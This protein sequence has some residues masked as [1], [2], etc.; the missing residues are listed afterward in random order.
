M[1]AEFPGL[2]RDL[3]KLSVE[4]AQ[5]AFET[6]LTTSEGAWRGIQAGS[7]AGRGM[8]ALMDK[9]AKITGANAEASFSFAL[10][11]RQVCGFRPDVRLPAPTTL[12]LGVALL[13]TLAGPRAYAAGDVVLGEKLFNQCKICHTIVQGKNGIA[14][15]L[16]GVIGR[17]AGTAPGFKYSD[18]MVKAG[19]GGLVW[20]EI[21]LDE[22][23]KDPK[24]K[25][26][27]NKMTFPGLGKDEDRANIIAFLKAT[28]Q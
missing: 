2:L 23:L 8:G 20:D 6:F 7:Q 14:P 22:Y 4:Q 18:A 27:G 1:T 25:V 13:M 10:K 9:V 24:T 5:R 16:F 26:P 12:V 3:F 19:E 21:T 28:A 15:S 17:K 11:L